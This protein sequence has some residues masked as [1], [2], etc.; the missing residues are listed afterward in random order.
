[1]LINGIFCYRAFIEQFS[2]IDDA[3][4]DQHPGENIF[5]VSHA[6]KIF[7]QHNL[8]LRNFGFYPQ[9]PIEKYLLG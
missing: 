9:N 6:G 1:M 3:I 2:V 4:P 8:D 7:N 5:Q